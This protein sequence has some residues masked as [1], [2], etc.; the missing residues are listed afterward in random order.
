M[1]GA[2]AEVSAEVDA[3]AD[4]NQPPLAQQA[5]TPWACW[6]HSADSEWERT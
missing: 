4:T 6:G 5:L 3:L 1:C 2:D